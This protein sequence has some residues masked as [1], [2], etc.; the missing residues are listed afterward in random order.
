VAQASTKVMRAWVKMGA[1]VANNT[2][3]ARNP[4]DGQSD[5]NASVPQVEISQRPIS[6]VDHNGL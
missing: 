5:F 2:I 6:E 4:I 1:H 3:M